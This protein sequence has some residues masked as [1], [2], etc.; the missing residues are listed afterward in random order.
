MRALDLLAST[1]R[2]LAGAGIPDAALEAEVLLMHAA[3]CTRAG[4]YASLTDSLPPGACQRLQ[5]LAG[6]R[7]GREPLAYVVGRREFFGLDLL[8]DASV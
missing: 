1:R 4:L 2:R 8:V 3:G 6:R 7:A 5:G